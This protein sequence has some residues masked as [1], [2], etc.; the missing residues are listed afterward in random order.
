MEPTLPPRRFVV[1]SRSWSSDDSTADWGADLAV[2]RPYRYAQGV[3][4]LA[5]QA[6][7]V[8]AGDPS[9]VIC[10]CSLAAAATWSRCCGS[11]GKGL[12]LFSKRLLF[13]NRLEKG[14]LRMA[15]PIAISLSLY[16][17]RKSRAFTLMVSMCRS[18]L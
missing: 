14:S 16:D 7:Q 5:A 18:G 3:D 15:P 8:L 9:A 4:G 6:Q 17:Y 2:G 10:S 12:C 11:M 13:S 1:C